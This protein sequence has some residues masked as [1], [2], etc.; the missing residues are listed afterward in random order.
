MIFRS[1]Y[2]AWEPKL[3]WLRWGN[4]LLCILPVHTLKYIS[5]ACNWTKNSR[6]SLEKRIFVK[7]CVIMTSGYYLILLT[8]LVIHLER[9]WYGHEKAQCEESSLRVASK[10]C[11]C[12][13]YLCVTKYRHP[14]FHKYISSILHVQKYPWLKS[15]SLRRILDR[16]RDA[17][18]LQ[19]RD[20]L[21]ALVV[22]TGG[23]RGRRRFRQ[24]QPVSR[25]FAVHCKKSLS[26][27]SYQVTKLTVH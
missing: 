25:Q 14:F 24:D 26:F 13:T 8:P 21:L 7:F 27:Q 19:E 6:M 5:G 4:G 23:S 16:S 10:Y 15:T 11:I 18:Q 17:G 12:P 9:H 22:D 1:V 20:A 2:R 3:W